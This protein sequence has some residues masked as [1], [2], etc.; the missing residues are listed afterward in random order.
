VSETGGG[1]NEPLSKER[2]QALSE[3]LASSLG[4]MTQMWERQMSTLLA[5]AAVLAAMPQTAEV[6]PKKVG[7]MIHLLSSKQS[8]PEKLR[9]EMSRMASMI[10]NASRRLR[11]ADLSK[12]PAASGSDASPPAGEGKER[13]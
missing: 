8:D 6:D 9:D 12:E 3:A 11:D 10:V 4:N 13:G 5:I 7:A 1:R 2:A